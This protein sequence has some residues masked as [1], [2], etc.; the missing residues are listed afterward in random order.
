M[1]KQSAQINWMLVAVYLLVLGGL[2]SLTVFLTSAMKLHVT[3]GLAALLIV[4]G[5]V[6]TAFFARG[7]GRGWRWVAT[8]AWT[9]ALIALAV[10]AAAI[11]WLP[12]A[13][14]IAGLCFLAAGILIYVFTRRQNIAE[15]A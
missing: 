10:Y 7:V 6:A 13:I 12:P 8:A 5:A 2:I 4:L 9:G 1:E 11:G 3:L 15:G 14:V